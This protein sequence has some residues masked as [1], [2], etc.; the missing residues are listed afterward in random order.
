MPGTCALAPNIVAQWIDAPVA[1]VN[2]A[3]GE[4]QQS[5]YLAVNPKG[6]VPAL[7]VEAGFILTEAAAIM[8]YLAAVAPDQ[9]LNPVD[10]L[11]WARVDEAMSYMTSEVHAAYGG[12]FAPFRFCESEAGQD[13]VR[14]ST[15]AKLANHYARLNGNFEANDGDYY[16]GQRTTADAYLYVITRWIDSTP[17]S[18]TDY[19][20]LRAFRV[21]MESDPDVKAALSRQG[22]DA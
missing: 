20:K 18:L 22:M 21:M 10:P 3:R 11:R 9:S 16:L 19:P 7:E 17:L 4:N 14:A 13:E 2:L 15:Y 5:D 1:I 8:R 6:M 12:H